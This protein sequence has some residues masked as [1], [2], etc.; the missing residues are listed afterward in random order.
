[1][2]LISNTYEWSSENDTLC[3]YF[4][5]FE[6]SILQLQ[7]GERRESQANEE[8]KKEERKARK[9]RK[10]ERE[11]QENSFIISLFFVVDDSAVSHKALWKALELMDKQ[12]DFLYLLTIVESMGTAN[13]GVY[14]FRISDD[15]VAG[16]KRKIRQRNFKIILAEESSKH[17][18]D[19][20]R[21]LLHR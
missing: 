19:M 2:K 3:G 21:A 7:K 20:G 16:K 1:M 18:D 11:T 9:G 6:I 4:S 17:C 10:R 14:G 5:F 13:M 8:R 15:W 12:K